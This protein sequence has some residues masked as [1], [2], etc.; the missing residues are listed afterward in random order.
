MKKGLF[1]FITTFGRALFGGWRRNDAMAWAPSPFMRENSTSSDLS[2]FAL[3]S[4]R[5]RY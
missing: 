5:N 3:K 4:V 1:I 2:V